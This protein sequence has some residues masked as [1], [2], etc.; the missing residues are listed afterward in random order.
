MKNAVLLCDDD[1]SVCEVITE[2]LVGKGLTVFGTT[3]IEVAEDLL[4]SQ[5]PPAVFIIDLKYNRPLTRETFEAFRDKYNSEAGSF[6]NSGALS[7]IAKVQK[8]VSDTRIILISAVDP[9]ESARKIGVFAYVA[10]PISDLQDNSLTCLVEACRLGP[11]RPEEMDISGKL[12]EGA[13]DLRSDL[14][15]SYLERFK[16]MRGREKE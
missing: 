5:N 7:L 13:L 11:L 12:R 16:Q 6:G 1:N 15:Q 3:D 8:E 2:L 10:K 9:K 4:L 14:F